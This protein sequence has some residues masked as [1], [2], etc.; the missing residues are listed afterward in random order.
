[1]AALPAKPPFRRAQPTTLSVTADGDIQPE[2]GVTGT[3][4]IDSSTNT[5]YVV[6]KSVIASGPTFYQR[7]HAIDLAT[8]NE[9]FSGPV[10][11][12]A[13]YPGNG[14]GGSTTT[15]VAQQENQRPGLALV[16]GDGVHRLGLA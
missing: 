8:G 5:L 16:N 2:V 3:P 10:N 1:M 7:L 15:F 14:D 4:V 9:K 11:I 12:A 13:T 6:S